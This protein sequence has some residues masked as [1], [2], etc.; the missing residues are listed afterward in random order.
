VVQFG[1]DWK[2]APKDVKNFMTELQ[3]LKTTLSETNTN[4]LLNPDFAE[5]F[6][7]RPSTLLSQLGA[8]APSASDTKVMLETCQKELETLVSD[9]MKRAKEHRVGWERLKGPFLVKDT[10]KLVE[11]LHRQCQIF[12][13]MLSIDAAVLGV[14]TYKEIKKAREEQQEWHKTEENQKILSWLSHLSF[15]DKQKDI[16]SK[17]HPGTGEWFLNK[18][19]F[20][21]WRDSGLDEPSILWCPGI[22]KC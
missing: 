17:H 22:R 7:D 11:M 14:T 6:Q 12:N 13:S 1:L 3:S 19:E 16:F 15:E 8:N 20:K 21:E 9:L 4:I 2:D 5:A 10:R 18:D